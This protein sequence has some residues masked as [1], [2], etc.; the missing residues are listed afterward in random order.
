MRRGRYDHIADAQAD[1]IGAV[2]ALL[3]VRIGGRE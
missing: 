3:I 2:D 1:P